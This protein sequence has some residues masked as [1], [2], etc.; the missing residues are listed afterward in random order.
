MATK[1][2]SKRT[3]STDKKT[4]ALDHRDC[5][6]AAGRRKPAGSTQDRTDTHLVTTDQK[7]CELSS[8][9]FAKTLSFGQL[10]FSFRLARRTVTGN[11]CAIASNPPAASRLGRTM[12]SKPTGICARCVRNAS[13]IHRFQRF[14]TTAGPV[15]LGIVIPMREDA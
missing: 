10:S 3:P 2:P 9:R 12:I 6:M 8:H 13:R 15:F 11:D 7:Y 14:R 1:N 4:I 5:I